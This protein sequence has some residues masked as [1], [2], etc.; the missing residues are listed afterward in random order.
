MRSSALLTFFFLF[1]AT[2]T[3]TDPSELPGQYGN[4]TIPHT[5][6]SENDEELISSFRSI[7]SVNSL[8]ID[9]N[10]ELIL[11]RYFDG[12]NASRTTNTKSASKSI[13]SLLI[14][15][16][17]DR[18][19]ISS[20]DQTL[21]E[22]FP[23]YFQLNPDP[24]KDSISIKDMLTMRTGLETT[25][26]H[27]YGRWVVSSD[28]VRFAL[29]QP[30]ESEPGGEMIYS[31][32]TSH[33]LSVILTKSSGM[34]TRAFA[35]KYLFRPMDIVPGGWDRDPQGYFMGGNNL[36]LR[37][38]DMLKIGRMV[39]NG[40][41]YQGNQI[42]SEN[43]LSDSFQVYTRSNFNPYDYGYLWW[44]RKTG[45]YEILFAW[46]HGGQYILL[47]PELDAVM[48]IT[49][50]LVNNDGSRR[51]QQLIFEWMEEYTIPYLENHSSTVSAL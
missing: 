7:G 5:Y 13:L 12:M 16:A 39:L 29:D 34:S 24:V 41:T 22:F 35:N 37:P 17:I 4:N 6:S 46:G 31:T 49:S 45:G 18:E 47:I 51:Y 48:A 3:D 33:L 38:A 8:L 26:F 19:Y 21:D 20:V 9:I 40:G 50:N 44:S 36:A 30:V 1:S 10:G 14:G 2:A 42:V 43:W 32:G 27:N 15:I 25:S 28:W 11:E 23:E